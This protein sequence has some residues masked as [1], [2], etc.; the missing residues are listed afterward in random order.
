MATLEHVFA[1]Y[2]FIQTRHPKPR[3]DKQWTIAWESLAEVQKYNP[4]TAL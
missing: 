1:V 3:L 2:M 4:N